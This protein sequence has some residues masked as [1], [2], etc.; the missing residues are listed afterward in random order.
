MQRT[1]SIFVGIVCLLLSLQLTDVEARHRRRIRNQNLS[2]KRKPIKFSYSFDVSDDNVQLYQSQSQTRDDKVVTGE[3]SWVDAL[4]VRRVTRYRA[5]D[6]GYHIL[7]MREENPVP[8]SQKLK[9]RVRMKEAFRNRKLRKRKLRK[10]STNNSI[11]R[12]SLSIRKPKVLRVVRKRKRFEPLT[13]STNALKPAPAKPLPIHVLPLSILDPNEPP[14]FLTSA[15][16]L[17]I[18]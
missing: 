18:I 10:L 14:L 4:G 13:L 1:I 8:K 12:S 5:D 9:S 16:S 2:I 3:Y 15:P 11:K 7:E 6:T 17:S